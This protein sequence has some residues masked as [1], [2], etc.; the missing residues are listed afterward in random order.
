MQKTAVTLITAMLLLA[1]QAT[2]LAQAP[3]GQNTGN[4]PGPANPGTP[5][6]LNQTAPR[7]A[8]APPATPATDVAPP[9]D[10]VLPAPVPGET[11]PTTGNQGAQKAEAGAPVPNNVPGAPNT[12][13]NVGIQGGVAAPAP[14]PQPNVNVQGGAQVNAQATGQGDNQWRFRWHAG[15]WW[16]WTPS[17]T[18]VVWIDNQWQPYAA[19]MFAGPTYGGGYAAP[20]Y[21]YSSPNYGYSSRNY[22]YPYP[23]GGGY[24]NTYGGGRS[25]VYLNFGSPRYN[26]GYRGYGAPGYGYGPGSGYGGRGGASVGRGGVGV[27]IRF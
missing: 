24:S 5:T 4:A 21:G 15:R 26:S 3:S 22:G 14:A 6:G 19:G 13:G 16:Y 25:G 12:P 17:N 8:G 7:E 9:V 11:R 27:G 23:Y 10:P 2:T 18:W 1:W 20:S